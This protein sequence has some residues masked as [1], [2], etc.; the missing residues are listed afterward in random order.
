MTSQLKVSWLSLLI[1]TLLKY[2]KGMASQ[3]KKF[4]G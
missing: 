4:R 1:S 3:L 2:S